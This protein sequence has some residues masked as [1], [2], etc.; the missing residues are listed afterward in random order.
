V[1]DP[2][3]LVHPNQLLPQDSR[4]LLVGRLEV[5]GVGPC[6]VTVRGESL[7]DLTAHVGPTMSDL[8][9]QDDPAGAVRS[10]P[11]GTTWP[12]AEV[13]TAT[14]QR[15][16]KRPRLIAPFD[17]SALKAA[18][19][20]FARS[21]VERVVE[22]RAKG[23]PA[24]ALALRARL[25]DTVRAATQVRPGSPEAADIKRRLVAEG[26]WSQYLEV[27]IGPDPEIF[28]KGQP[29]SAVGTGALIGVLERS[30]WNNPEPEVVLAV[31]STGRAVGATLGNDVNLRDFE[32]RSALLLAEAKDNNAS[33]AVG[34]MIRLFSEDFTVDQVRH[35]EVRLR[36]VGEDGF[37]HSAVS[38]V[39]EMSRTFE[40][41][42]SH[43]MGDHHQ[44]PDGAALFAGTMFAPTEDRDTPG[45]GFTHHLGDQVVI[46]TTELGTL[47]NEVTTAESAPRWVTGAR[48]LMRNLAGRGLLG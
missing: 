6:L 38:R 22:E 1:P 5:P 4:A 2:S 24:Q 31:S 23:D 18:G 11:G 21:M 15:D 42:I 34:P 13:L 9:D 26:L 35:S 33:C 3:S 36:I 19:V 47:I 10:A 41:L 43:T 37:D 27:G 20:T 32:G 7:V 48:A 30:T 25:G 12:L 40:E 46:S 44:Y 39:A 29:L 17:L 16:R 45:E 28:T 8:L 14:L